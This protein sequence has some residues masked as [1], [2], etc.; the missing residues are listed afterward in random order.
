M[1]ETKVVKNGEDA[2]HNMWRGAGS[3]EF[4]P[5]TRYAVGIDLGTT[6]SCVALWWERDASVKVISVG[7]HRVTP[8]VVHFADKDKVPIVGGAARRNVMENV[9]NY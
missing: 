2:V 5:G 3:G 8:S 7:G 6:N 1:L 9:S 4:S